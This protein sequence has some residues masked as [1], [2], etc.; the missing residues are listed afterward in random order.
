MLTVKYQ[1]NIIS[2]Q[3]KITSMLHATKT[4]H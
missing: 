1:I 4:G 3:Y 2:Y